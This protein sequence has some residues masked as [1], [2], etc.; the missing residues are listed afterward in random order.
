LGALPKN[1]H[2]L[3]IAS[4]A[5]RDH[6]FRQLAAPG[7]DVQALAE[8]L[9]DPL[10]GGFKVKTIVNK[11]WWAV[12][13]A[14]A[15]LFANRDPQDALLLY[16]SCHGVKNDDGHLYFATSDTNREILRASA[17]PDDFVQEQ[18]R[19]SRARQ[20]VLILD[21]C[22]G[23]FFTNRMLSKSEENKVDDIDRFQAHGAAILTGS[24]AIQYSF[25]GEGLN[26]NSKLSVFTS[27]LVKGLSSGA[28][29]LD[30]DGLISAVDL[31]GYARRQ[32]RSESRTQ[33]PT[34]STIGQEGEIYI[35]AVPPSKRRKQHGG[36]PVLPSPD[37]WIDLT[38]FL[39]RSPG[40]ANKDAV[41]VAMETSLA[42]SG[43][44]VLLSHTDL[45]AKLTKL[46]KRKLDREGFVVNDMMYVIDHIGVRAERSKKVYTAR[47]FRL[48]S[49]DDIVGQLRLGRPVVAGMGWRKRWLDEPISKTGKVDLNDKDRYSGGSMI[50][51][52]GCNEEDMSI[53]FM[54]QFGWG[55]RGCG[56]MSKETATACL[57]TSP[58]SIEA[59]E[60]TMPYTRST[61]E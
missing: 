2:A 12:Q 7:A 14:I 26:N 8:V 41:L 39:D 6:A 48:Q 36:S 29:D 34:L 33:I 50:T 19:T 61:P 47:S 18:M 54:W 60:I 37:G 46:T 59:A 58:F 49:I 45:Q 31:I 5:Y 4:A 1:R 10:V 42:F 51:I 40:A 21:C 17:V 22:Y 52:V 24:N 44:R 25:E 20:Q 38:R 35:A 15:R 28:A 57:H 13:Q 55:D 53:R 32:M 11:S 56:W 16:F 43:K 9:G 27:S 3:L 23:G 30:G